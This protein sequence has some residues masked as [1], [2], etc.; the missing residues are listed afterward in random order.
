MSARNDTADQ[1][2][3]DSNINSND[4]RRARLAIHHLEAGRDD[5]GGDDRGD[6]VAGA[7]HVGEGRHDELRAGFADGTFW[8]AKRPRFP[9]LDEMLQ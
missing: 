6:G 2:N 3:T 9:Y 4:D 7:L 5:P 8:P 1:S